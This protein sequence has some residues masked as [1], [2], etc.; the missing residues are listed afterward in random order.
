MSNNTLQVKLRMPTNE[1]PV[2]HRVIV[3]EVYDGVETVEYKF[4]RHTPLKQVWEM[5]PRL[6]MDSKFPP[7]KKQKFSSVKKAV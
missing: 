5:I 7:K 1:M 2:N 4:G 3:A 6:Y